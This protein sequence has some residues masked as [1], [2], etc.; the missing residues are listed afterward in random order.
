M[1]LLMMRICG[2]T[3]SYV[4]A[5]L[6]FFLFLIWE[7]LEIDAPQSLSMVYSPLVKIGHF[8]DIYSGSLKII[9]LFLLN[10]G[11]L[12]HVPPYSMLVASLLVH[13][14]PGLFLITF[15]GLAN[16]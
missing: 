8:L 13:S 5:I 11:D 12:Q 15:Y 14:W 10:F 16:I 3:K 4:K 7:V 9:F 6:D 1:L 2:I